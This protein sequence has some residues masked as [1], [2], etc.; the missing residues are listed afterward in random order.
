MLFDRSHSLSP[1]L[2]LKKFHF[3]HILESLSLFSSNKYDIWKYNIWFT[4]RILFASEIERTHEF[5]KKYSYNL[6]H[7]FLNIL[8]TLFSLNKNITV[9]FKN[10]FLLLYM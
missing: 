5:G 10:L 7:I 3:F 1:I 6:F 4:W 8:K 9:L 2:F